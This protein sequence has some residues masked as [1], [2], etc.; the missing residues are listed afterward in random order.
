MGE[1]QVDGNRD[2]HN[3][4]RARPSQDSEIMQKMWGRQ[5]QDSVLPESTSPGFTYFSNPAILRRVQWDSQTDA[6]VI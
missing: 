5:D 1:L 2:Q 4:V 6:T 3:T